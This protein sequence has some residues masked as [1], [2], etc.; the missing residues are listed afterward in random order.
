MS[1][2]VS[3]MTFFFFIND[4]SLFWERYTFIGKHVDFISLLKVFE[5]V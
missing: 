3:Y 5:Y 4:I 1:V 2:Q